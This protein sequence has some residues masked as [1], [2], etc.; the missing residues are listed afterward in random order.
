MKYKVK[1]V[2]GFRKDEAYSIDAEEAHKAY[3][4]F[5]NPDARTV[6]S[7]GL[8]IKGTEIDRI[9]PDYVGT[10]GWNH[11][12]NMDNDDWNE[13]KAAGVDKSLQNILS[14]AKE[15]AHIATPELLNKPLSLAFNDVR[16]LN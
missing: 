5:Y 4:L 10:M 15:V 2:C 13:V 3:Y 8:A 12:H 6:F 9:E 1:I 16:L 11:A 7:N 14:Q